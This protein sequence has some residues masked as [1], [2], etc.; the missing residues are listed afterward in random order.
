MRNDLGREIPETDRPYRETPAPAAS[1]RIP[2]KAKVGSPAFPKTLSEAFDILGVRD[3]MTLSFHHHLRDGDKVLNLALAEIRR[4]GLKGLTIAAS[5]IFPCHAPLVPLIEDGSVTGIVANYMNGPVADA[6]CAGKLRNVAIMDTHGGRARAIEAGELPIDVAI[7]AAPTADRRGNA[8]GRVGQSACGSLGYAVPDATFAKKVLLVTDHLVDR[9]PFADIDGSR[10]DA[11]LAV[12]S[13]GDPAGIVSGT[14][15]IT[16]EPVGLKIARDAVK[17]LDA[18]GMVRDG[19]SMQTGA[20]GTSLA[21]AAAVRKLM[22]TK[23][24][25]GGFASGGI[26]AQYV[27]M[28]EKG[29]V[30]R[31]EDVQ[32]FDLEAV[33]SIRENKDHHAISASEYGN[34]FHRPAPVVDG[35]DFVILGAT[36]VDLDFNVNVTTD[37]EGRIIGGSGGHAD[38]AAGA[39]CTVVVTN[40]VK[41]R[42]PIVMERVTCVTTPGRD[43]D[44]V[45][46]ERGIAVHPRRTDLLERLAGS[47]LDVVPI[48][49]L[50]ERAHAMT[51][52]PNRPVRNGRVVALVRYRDGSI[53]DAV[54]AK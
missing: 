24:V 51:G 21:V 52:I 39:F 48:R 36:E 12:D 10:V 42:L 45:V 22:E 27:E 26:T 5:S 18:C 32:D 28:L 46:T 9:A 47:G 29:L 2:P 31:L 50:M 1:K 20:G 7:L 14:T 54:R 6:V 25:K 30:E 17:L 23:G 11:V 43:V 40:L 49:T 44:V 4:R 34:P 53:I 13:I 41:A 16:K 35:L 37:S 33:R 8:T 38:T 15:R 3:G 19:M